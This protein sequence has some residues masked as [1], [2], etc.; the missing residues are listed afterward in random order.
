MMKTIC[1]SNVSVE[2]LQREYA[3][4]C[5]Q[6]MQ[7][8][9]TKLQHKIQEYNKQMEITVSKMKEELKAETKRI[10]EINEK[11]IAVRIEQRTGF[12]KENQKIEADKTEQKIQQL[13]QENNNIS[14]GYE[15]KINW[16]D[17]MF[18][19][20]MINLERHAK[21]ERERAD[22]W[23]QEFEKAQKDKRLLES[24]RVQKLFLST[25]LNDWLYRL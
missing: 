1:M 24:M 16:I 2:K 19:Q 6:S 13:R 21:G 17:L 10:K 20:Q 7:E 3:Q 22:H 9:N 23:K 5:F 11:N 18:K 25:S 15:R 12:L 14:V 4:R 8:E